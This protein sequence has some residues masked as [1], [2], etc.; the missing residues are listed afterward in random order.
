MLFKEIY[1]KILSSIREIITFIK[2]RKKKFIFE[3]N[4]NVNNAYDKKF[5]RE[6][7]LLN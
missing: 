7:H 6:Y 3:D 5:E 2:T 4:M 1:P